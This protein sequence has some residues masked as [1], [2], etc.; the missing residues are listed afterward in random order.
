[1]HLM[2]R[3]PCRAPQVQEAVQAS[4]ATLRE[5]VAL[6][7][8]LIL[9]HPG[10]VVGVYTHNAAAPGAGALT[11]AVAVEQDSAAS[12]AAAQSGVQEAPA[13]VATLA[14]N[15]AMQAA[16]MQPLAVAAGDLP[17]DTI[18]AERAQ[19][20]ER[21]R[22]EAPN[23]PA[24]ILERIVDGRLAKWRGDTVMLEQGYVLDEESTVAAEIGRVAADTG[25]PLRVAGFAVL[26]A[27]EHAGGAGM[28]VWESR[29]E[30][31]AAP[32]KG[33]NKR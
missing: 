30:A 3:S 24:H 14:R 13:A 27:G 12:G 28:P 20:L 29:M 10:A 15:L 16:A 6:G 25:A 4:A 17:A 7:R 5:N 23:K 33:A 1:M 32:P 2:F 31:L 18:A 9:H 26:K 21:A 22:T 11:A 8:T 19:M